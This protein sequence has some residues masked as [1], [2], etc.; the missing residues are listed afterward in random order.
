ME[1]DNLHVSEEESIPPSETDEKETSQKLKK[2]AKPGIIYLSSVPEYMS[3]Q[4]LRNTFEEYGEINRTFFQP[5][6]KSF[7]Y[8][9]GLLFSEGWVEFRSKKDAKCVALMLNNTQVG[10]KKR[11]PWY[12]CIWNIKCL[13]KFTWTDV[14]AD[15]EL[16]RA[17]YDSR[18]RADIA[19]VKKQTNYYVSNYEKSKTLREMKKRK[20]K[21]GQVFEKRTTVDGIPQKLTDEEIRANKKTMKR[22]SNED[23][24]DKKAKEQRKTFLG[25][26]EDASRKFVMK[27]IFG[28]S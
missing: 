18:I 25:S 27:N 17:T 22:Q 26:N 14:N 15:R 8:K 23:F 19:Q 7:G 28:T 16:K 21:K 1:K 11:H 12:N 2:I 24:S 5:I 4:K 13:P 10:G 9:K 6:E 20:E 3:V